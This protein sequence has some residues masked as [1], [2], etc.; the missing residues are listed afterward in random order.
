MDVRVAD[1][2]ALG[3][4]ELAT[5][6]AFCSAQ[7]DGL[8]PSYW[9]DIGD[10][11]H[12]IGEE[13]GA[14]IAHACIVPLELRAAGRGLHVGY[15]E[16]VCTL[17]ERRGEGLG[18]VVME[19]VREEIVSRGLELGALD[20]GVPT[21]FTRLGWEPWRGSLWVRTDDAAERIREEEGC[22]H[23]LRTPATPQRLRF[24]APLSAPWRPEPW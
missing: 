13:A 12:V 21:F 6:L 4:D 14:T 17:A 19:R 24:D 1:R 2:S 9:D 8:S 10:G 5:L 23:V 18:T 7:F 11:V 20:T 16:A 15:V 3:D 22:V